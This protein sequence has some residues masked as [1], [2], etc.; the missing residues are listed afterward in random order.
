MDTIIYIKCK[1]YVSLMGLL[2]KSRSG[3]HHS[4][5]GN[6]YFCAPSTFQE[7]EGEFSMKMLTLSIKNQNKSVLFI[8][9][10]VAAVVALFVVPFVVVAEIHMRVIKYKDHKSHH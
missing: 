10:V 8:V 6:V 3:L 1:S 9:V 2:S 5:A 4:Q 7:R